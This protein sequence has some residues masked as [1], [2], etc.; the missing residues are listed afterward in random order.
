MKFKRHLRS[1]LGLDRINMAPMIDI[2]LQ[3][4]IFFMLT[5][6]FTVQTGIN[7]KLPRAVTSDVV[8]EENFIVSVTSEDVMYFNNRIVTIKELRQLLK[9]PQKLRRP[10]LIK[11]DRRAAMGRIVDIWDVCRELGIEKINFA[12]S[13]DQ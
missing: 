8:R 12:T 10:V 1:D 5:S 7:V 6:S 11:A 3:L 4:L 2:I 9:T 13:K